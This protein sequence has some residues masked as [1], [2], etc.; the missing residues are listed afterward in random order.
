MHAR[1]RALA[2]LVVFALCTGPLAPTVFAQ[3]KAPELENLKKQMLQMEE[4]FRQLQRQIEKLEK[5]AAPSG[6]PGQP[7][8]A[9]PALQKKI[10]EVESKADAA[11]AA[12]K[13]IFPSQFNPSIS[14]A[15]DT[16]GSYKSNAQGFN[17]GDG[18]GT[19]DAGGRINNSRPA[20]A[21]FNLRTAELFISAD[22]DPFTRA[23]AT[24]NASADAANN[25]EAA[26]TVEEAAIVTTRLPYNLTIRGGRFFADFGT[27]V[28]RHDHDLPFVDRPPSLDVLVG[29]EGQTNG[30]EVSWLAPTPFFLRA[31]ATVGNKFGS[32]FR[33]GVS[34]LNSRPIKGL[35][36]L[37]RLQTY[38]DINDDNNVELGGSIAEAPSA[39]D[40]MHT[41]RFERRLVGMDFKYRWYPLGYGVRQSLTVAGEL[42]HDVGDADPLNGG[43]RR[44]VLG[45]PV[46]QGAWGGYVYAEYRLSKQWRPG[47]RFDY[48]QLQSEPLLV[49]N[50]FTGLPASTLNATGHRTDNRTWTAYLTWFPSEFQRLRLQYNRSD[51]GNAQDA[52]EFFLQWTAFLGSH[53]HG[54]SE[55]E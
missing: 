29:G 22:V 47:V 50:P 53:S 34:N 21:D 28:H 44:D 4:Q 7:Q 27:L 36:Y 43:P 1:S 33:D 9:D 25:D 15:I 12:S 40:V 51:R 35:T 54:F 38:F 14:L 39:E 32:D 42:L 41:G 5:Q 11:L 16:I 31:S 49:T 6:A 10:Q 19:R 17:P 20:G 13:K 23:F 3:E 45:N 26:L 30:V 37:G 52:N 46:R 8:A 2:L 24:I 55:R 48:F 18:T